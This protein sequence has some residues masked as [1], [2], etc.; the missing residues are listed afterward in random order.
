MSELLYLT[1]GHKLFLQPRHVKS[2]RDVCA[3]S[4]SGFIQLRRGPAVYITLRVWV[5]EYHL[6][7]E[8]VYRNVPVSLQGIQD[9]WH[10]KKQQEIVPAAC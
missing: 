5:G 7:R 9:A 1:A 3:E 6:R 2:E 4:R 10:E 8:T